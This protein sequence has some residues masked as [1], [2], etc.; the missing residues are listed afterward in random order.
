VLT[1]AAMD[2][3]RTTEAFVTTGRSLEDAFFLERDR[4]LIARRAE[5]RKLAE[6][7]EAL[8]SVSGIKDPEVLD[9][10]VKLNVRPETVAALSMVPL[11]E[12]VWADGKVDEQERKVVLDFATA[13]GMGEGQVG[14][15]LLER[16][17]E[18]RPEPTL[19]AAWQRYIEALCEKL[20]PDQRK[21]LRDELLRNVRAA[22]EASGGFLGIGK[23]SDE[24]KA[25][26]AKLETSFGGA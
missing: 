9:F 7:K 2:G 21:H 11:V 16:W 19:L 22:A 26:L 6:T 17:I 8:A 25:V 15:E 1:S 23:I 20:S 3:K 5:L 13:Q 14:R 12:V 18:Q 4:Q 10:L 24:E